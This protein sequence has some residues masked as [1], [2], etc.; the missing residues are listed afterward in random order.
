MDAKTGEAL[1]FTNVFINNTTIGAITD[2]EGNYE[3]K[4]KIPSNLELVA[5]FVGYVT[6]VE[7]VI[8]GNRNSVTVNFSLEPQQSVLSEVELKSRRDRVWERSLK[9]FEDVFIAVPD[10]PIGGRLAKILNPWVIDFEQIK[11]NNGANYVKATAQEPIII[12]NDALGYRVE[13]H[14]QDYRWSRTSSRYY[15]QVF[16]TEKTPKDEKEAQ[17]WRDN[18]ESSYQ[19]SS[20]HL[21]QSIIL[22]QADA[23]GFRM[24][25]S[26]E[27]P[28]GR[29]RTN[30]FDVEFGETILPFPVDSVRRVSLENG[31]FRIFWPQRV[32]IHYLKKYALNEY[33]VDFYHPISWIIAPNGYF[34]V[35]RDGIPAH[36]TQLVLSGRM[37][38]Q[39][40]ARS[41]PYNFVP[42][43]DFDDFVT[44]VDSTKRAFNQWNK[45]REQ[46]YFSTNKDFYYPGEGVWLGGRMI[47][48]NQLLADSLS[49]VVYVD[50][51]D[52]K[53]TIIQKEIFPIVSGRIAGGFTLPDNLKAGDY[54]L[55]AYTRWMLNYPEQDIFLRPIPVLEKGSEII[56][57]ELNEVEYYGDI[58]ITQTNKKKVVP[59]GIELQIDLSI[60]DELDQAI[61]AEFT[62]SLTDGDLVSPITTRPTILSA[63]EWLDQEE[64]DD[65]TLTIQN[66]IE[67]GITVQGRFVSNR[68]RDP[69]INPITLVLDDLA[70]FGLVN[71]DSS[72]YF[73]ATGL[74]FTD[75][76]RLAAAALDKKKKSY[77]SI[78]L[79][80]DSSL[81]HRGSFPKL[82]Y[83]LAQ[84]KVGNQIYDIKGEYILMEEF[85]K[86]DLKIK[87]LQDSNYGY[88]EPD[89]QVTQEMLQNWPGSTLSSIV[90]MQF[91]NGKLGNFNY[92][93]KA[94]NPLIIIDGSRYLYAEGESYTDVLDRY[95]TDEVTSLSI[96]TFNAPVFGMAG[97]AGV[98]MFETIRGERFG[99]TTETKFDNTGFQSFRIRGYSPVSEFENSIA[100]DAPVQVRPTIYWDPKG[101]VT[102]ENGV[103]SIKTLLSREVEKVN[104][105]IEGITQDGLGF[106]KTFQIKVEN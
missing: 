82:S 6:K 80:R 43:L 45:L 39:R 84:A 73:R 69:I 36:P 105:V 19:G 22:N 28:L 57:Q 35:Y 78:E 40:V 55:R 38:R 23:Q 104:L 81:I 60:L 24:Y 83:Q 71:T 48:Q 2:L 14:L 3:I 93:I 17:L 46:P 29:E 79:I 96:Y 42:D 106:V 87:R 102:A 89:R 47:Y 52:E 95:I 16:Y 59:K 54:F 12:D 85:I 70:D 101:K 31:N 66:Q 51:L 76:A 9:R 50:L 30:S 4:G 64:K 98:I 34:D 65:Q 20:R 63:L 61:G 44:E 13:F 25:E 88:G 75:S 8:V 7:E 103:Y 21:I 33:Y 97:F 27:A 41:L 99:P 94:G 11:V 74:N 15:G 18:R 68:K 58:N 5:S 67:Y 1:P 37:G 53:S 10:D 72:G 32:E 62:V 56:T 49:R 26:V 92:G 91:G 90:G 77:G 100:K 86:E